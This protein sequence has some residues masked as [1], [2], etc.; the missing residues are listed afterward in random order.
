MAQPAPPW[1]ALA[2]R[3]MPEVMRRITE[4][5]SAAK[6]PLQVGTTSAPAHWFLLDSLL[7]ANQA[8]RE[9]MHA[10]ALALTRQCVEAIGVIEL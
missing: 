1:F 9:G 7:L 2:E 3:A 10:N 5:A 6:L 8:N 4:A